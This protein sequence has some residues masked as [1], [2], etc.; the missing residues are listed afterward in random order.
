ME[1]P[2]AFYRVSVK[3]LILNYEKQFLLAKEANGFWELLGGGLDFGEDPI[4]GLKREILEE[5]GLE[6]THVAEHPSYFL[7]DKTRQG[8]WIV[9]ILYKTSVRDLKFTASDECVDLKYFD[10]ESVKSIEAFTN[11]LK[12][13]DIFNPTDHE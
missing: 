2:N 11:V 10:K 9:N 13:A 4:V 5:T 6:V 7:T 12:L 1:V 8:T 3:A